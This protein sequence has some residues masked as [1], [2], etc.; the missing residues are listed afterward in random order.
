MAIGFPRLDRTS[1]SSH[2]LVSQAEHNSWSNV[3]NT[4]FYT[5]VTPCFACANKT[6]LLGLHPSPG[7]SFS[8]GGQKRDARVEGEPD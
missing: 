6:A 8:L 3:A 4:E 1:F 5:I 7:N 2:H